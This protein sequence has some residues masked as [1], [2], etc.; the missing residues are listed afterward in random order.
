MRY[1]VKAKLSTAFGVVIVL[2]AAAGAVSYTK[3]AA[4]NENVDMIVEGRV[5]RLVWAE[6]MKVHVLDSIRSEKNAIIATSDAERERDAANAL[7]ARDEARKLRETIYEVASAKGKEYIVKVA[8][9]VESANPVQDKILKYAQ[10][11]SANKALTIT[12][13][14]GAEAAKELRA[15][16]NAFSDAGARNGATLL[17]ADLERIHTSIEKLRADL[18]SFIASQTVVDRETRVKPLQADAAAITASADGVKGAPSGPEWRS[19]RSN[20]RP[21]DRWL[22]IEA[23]AVE[24]A[25]EGGAI[26]AAD[27]SSGEG[28]AHTLEVLKAI[29]EFIGFQRKM[30]EEAKAQAAADY[31]QARILADRYAVRFGGRRDRRGLVDRAQYKPGTRPRCRSRQ[32][33]RHRRSEPARLGRQR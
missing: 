5:K 28:R 8:Q 14:E 17:V 16:L 22:K 2:S 10:M 32:C 3:L 13:T 30:V 33:G 11:N 31:E 6:E 9:A 21:L 7:K 12:A 18:Y 23:R 19:P 15:A 26:L 1:T 20:S 27:L 4:L 25:R 29:D 24:I